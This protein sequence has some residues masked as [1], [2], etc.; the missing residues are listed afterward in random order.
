MTKVYLVDHDTFLDITQDFPIILNYSIADIN[1]PSQRTLEFSN[2]FVVPGTNNNNQLLEH[3]YD[4]GQNI[5]NFN[6]NKKIA[7]VVYVDDIE[8]IRGYLKYVRSNTIDAFAN[9]EVEYTFE[10]LGQRIDFYN[11]LKFLTGSVEDKKIRDLSAL[12]SFTHSFVEQEIIDS[13]DNTWQDCY[14]Y[15]LIDYGTDG[16]DKL[17]NLSF[18]RRVN[19]TVAD[20]KPALF[21]KFVFDKIFEEAGYT[22]TSNFLNSDV[23]KKM[24]L[25]YDK[26]EITFQNQ[27]KDFFVGLSASRVMADTGSINNNFYGPIFG[28]NSLQNTYI[29]PPGTNQIRFDLD[30]GILENMPLNEDPTLYNTQNNYNTAN[31]LYT[32]QYQG[33][34]SFYYQ[35]NFT[36]DY[37]VY[38]FGDNPNPGTLATSSWFPQTGRKPFWNVVAELYLYDATSGIRTELFEDLLEDGEPIIEGN[39]YQ[40]AGQSTVILQQGHFYYLEMGLKADLNNGN[41]FGPN[42][43]VAT[44]QRV[45][46][47]LSVEQS[48]WG[49]DEGVNITNQTFKRN[50]TIQFN[51]MNGFTMT[52]RDFITGITNL[53]NLYYTLEPG[54]KNFIIEPRDEF[55]LDGSQNQIDWT[56]N[57]D[58]ESI[59]QET[60]YNSDINLRYKNDNDYYN[61]RYEELY[62]ETYGEY[63]QTVD[64]DFKERIFLVETT[65]SPTPFRRSRIDDRLVLSVIVDD[66]FNPYEGNQRILFYEGTQSMNAT[67]ELN[68][69]Q[70]NYYPRATHLENT[71]GA[72][73]LDL[74]YSFVAPFYTDID[75]PEFNLTNRNLYNEFWRNTINEVASPNNRLLKGKVKLSPLDILSLDFRKIYRLKDNLYRLNSLVYNATSIELS[76]FEFIRIE[77]TEIE[78]DG[79]TIV[80]ATSPELEKPSSDKEN[81]ISGK[82]ISANGSKNVING[83]NIIVNGDNN[84]I[85][86]ENG[87]VNGNNNAIKIQTANINGSNF[88]PDSEIRNVSLNVGNG[89]F[90]NYFYDETTFGQEAMAYNNDLL[91]IGGQFS[92][93]DANTIDSI[94]AIDKN[95][96]KIE[97]TFD[98][99]LLNYKYNGNRGVINTVVYWQD[100]IIVGGS[101]ENGISVMSI[102]GSLIDT[103]NMRLNVGISATTK[104]NE[105]K[106]FYLENDDLYVG[107]NFLGFISSTGSVT[108]Q[109]RNVA[110]IDLNT[111]SASTWGFDAGANLPIIDIDELDSDN[112]LLGGQFTTYNSQIYPKIVSVSK[113]TGGIYTTFSVSNGFDSDVNKIISTTQSVY[114]GGKFASYKSTT[115]FGLTKLSMTGSIIGSFSADFESYFGS[116]SAHSVKDILLLEDD[117]YVFGSFNQVNNQQLDNMAILDTTFGYLKTLQTPLV[118][119]GRLVRKGEVPGIDNSSISSALLVDDKLYLAGQFTRYNHL[120]YNSFIKVG[121]DLYPDESTIIPEELYVNEDYIDEDYFD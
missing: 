7:A 52:Q 55:Y 106:T 110:K 72:T 112:I 93:Y 90:K 41:Q 107:G 74:N 59:I 5:I 118:E 17:M 87:I 92:R 108:L 120:D 77:N 40:I 111:F 67:I 63:I 61:D 81:V 76:D 73:G 25:P 21:A 105:V 46:T 28:A 58:A 10:F 9:N 16:L 97:S 33:D 65:F 22:Y 34:Y 42:T 100:H 115:Q 83:Q 68:N 31:G 96:G 27:L 20:F 121:L 57:I 71:F 36:I 117:V 86:G 39:V 14:V 26:R 109:R 66:N 94:I 102:T 88:K 49:A 44:G 82:S 103:P 60:I 114:V 6:P 85:F 101:F 62:E 18:N 30:S 51:Q 78:V 50:N 91:Y 48:V 37:D 116:N 35:V 19:L 95:T 24:I 32:S 8:V 4:I 119:P 53:F 47:R 75:G 38:F 99:G 1:I 56:E 29:I 104:S 43:G 23:F 54:T 113:S 3:I 64:S 13:W 89:I 2:Q 11:Q 70:Y 69:I 15:P 98:P 80:E 79:S 84:S 12:N 45:R